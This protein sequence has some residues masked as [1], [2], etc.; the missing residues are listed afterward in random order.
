[1]ELVERCVVREI[2]ERDRLA[3][4]SSQ[5][6]HRTTHGP[7]VLTI[8]CAQ[9]RE[10][11]HSLRDCDL[12]RQA[13]RA[14][15][16]SVVQSVEGCGA[17]ITRVEL[18]ECDDLAF[19]AHAH[20]FVG[21]QCDDRE[22]TGSLVREMTMH[23]AGF[24]HQDCAGR[25]APNLTAPPPF[26]A[27]AFHA[28]DCVVLFDSLTECVGGAARGAK[29]GHRNGE[30]DEFQHASKIACRRERGSGDVAKNRLVDAPGQ[31]HMERMQNKLVALVTGANKGIGLQIAKDLAGHGFTVLL[32]SRK[33]EQGEAAAKSIGAQAHALQLDVT[34][35]A[36]I[37]AAAERIGKEFGRL[38]VLVN[39][40]GISNAQKPG[41]SFEE[42]MMA[43][44]PSQASLAEVRAVFETNVFGVIAV[45]QALLPLLREAPA[46]R[47]VNVS[48]SLGSLTMQT[49]P[50]NPYRSFQS[51]T[52]SPS[53]TALNA[54]TVAFA[55][56]LEPTRIKVNAACPGYTAT[57][58]NNFSGTR[59]VEQ[60]AREPVRLALLDANGPTG[61]FS[62]ENGAVPW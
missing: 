33:L 59:T 57:E 24:F 19:V 53:K 61:T 50:S 21:R 42:I 54:I 23:I 58:L 30:L 22:R 1:M 56:E 17:W 36:S 48:S 28:C 8:R 3:Q 45:T 7:C 43:G 35:Q 47:I 60:A 4:S 40:A 5:I 16:Y 10:R 29:T 12:E 2:I 14:R 52:Y 55:I 46:G 25:G 34:N 9:P 44:R 11:R 6:F 18:R 41:L 39:N 15:A 38:D 27:A 20:D 31:T 49:D 13:I 26:G 37:S 32:G 51:T 62:D